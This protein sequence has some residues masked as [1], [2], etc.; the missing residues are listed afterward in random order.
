MKNMLHSSL[1]AAALFAGVAPTVEA[2]VDN[3]V[4]VVDERPGRLQEM[5]VRKR[6]PRQ[7]AAERH[8]YLDEEA[9]ARRVKREKRRVDTVE[10]I[11]DID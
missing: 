3:D 4:S 1:V 2:S 5:R 9:V 11:E 8:E 6:G 10:F 7:S